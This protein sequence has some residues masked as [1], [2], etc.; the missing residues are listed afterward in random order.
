M[1]RE[2]LK[3][4]QKGQKVFVDN[5]PGEI[6]RITPNTGRIAV[7]VKEEVYHFNKDGWGRGAQWQLSLY[8]WTPEKELFH[9]KRI[10]FKEISRAKVDDLTIDQLERILAILKEETT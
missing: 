10:M 2:W 8:E 9:K 6:L 1:D 3:S 7:K 4:A 5:E